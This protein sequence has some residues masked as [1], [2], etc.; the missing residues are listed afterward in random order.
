MADVSFAVGINRYMDSS[1]QIGTVSTEKEIVFESENKRDL[2]IKF[3]NGV[4]G[5]YYLPAGEKI[6]I[7]SPAAAGE[8]YFKLEAPDGTDSD[9]SYYEIAT[10]VNGSE[11]ECYF[12]TNVSDKR[13]LHAKLVRKIRHSAPTI[14]VRVLNTSGRPVPIE[15]NSAPHTCDEGPNDFE[16][17]VPASKEILLKIDHDRIVNVQERGDGQSGGTE[18]AEI[19]IIGP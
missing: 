6:K 18:Q 3:E 4:I 13:I 10:Q 8:Y 9:S 19:I 15:I 2:W 14:A 5:P 12:R 11:S 1:F 16:I 7:F 17:P